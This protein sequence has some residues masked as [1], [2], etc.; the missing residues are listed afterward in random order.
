MAHDA[1]RLGAHDLRPGLGGV[2]DLGAVVR[3]ES[4]VV[5]AQR[6]ERRVEALVRDGDLGVEAGRARKDLGGRVVATHL[7]ER[8]GSHN[9]GVR[10]VRALFGYDVEIRD[11]LVVAAQ[12]L[13]G[14]RARD[15]CHRVV[16]ELDGA[17]VLPDGLLGPAG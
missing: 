6:V 2:D 9:L 14:R 15:A 10:V 16:L 5:P 4:L 11:A 13:Q 8:H 3:V 7:V 17:A 12:A 1:Q